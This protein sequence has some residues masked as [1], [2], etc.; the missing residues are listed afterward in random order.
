MSGF[1]NQ[2]EKPKGLLGKI[3]GK[4][5]FFENRKINKWTI[6]HLDIKRGDRILEIGY[7]PGYA[8]KHIIE[9]YEQVTIDGVDVSNKMKTEAEKVNEEGIKSGKVQLYTGDIAEFEAPADYYDKIFSVNNYPLWEKP[10]QSLKNVLAMLAPGGKI[11]FTVQP[12]EEDANNGTAAELGKKIKA[13]L[14]K[15]GFQQITAFYK[16]FRPVRTVCVTAL[17]KP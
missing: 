10:S 12:R 15:A 8:I 11:A 6:N 3:A 17:K 4:I 14:E 16:H 2:F 1:V 5:M 7:G 9:K 13:D